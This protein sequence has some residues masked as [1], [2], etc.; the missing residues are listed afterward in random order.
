MHNNGK[1]KPSL[2]NCRPEKKIDVIGLPGSLRMIT[3]KLDKKG[4]QPH[5]YKNTE[6]D[7]NGF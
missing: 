5:E 6:Q 4:A 2:G 7:K 3:C 1:Q